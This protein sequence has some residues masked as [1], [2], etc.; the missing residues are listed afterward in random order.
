MYGILKLVILTLY[1]RGWSRAL[2]W[3]LV[4]LCQVEGQ[5]EAPPWLVLKG[6][7]FKIVDNNL[8]L[9]FF[10]SIGGNIKKSEYYDI[11]YYIF[12]FYL[13]HKCVL[14]QWQFFYFQVKGYFFFF[15]LSCISAPKLDVPK[16]GILTLNQL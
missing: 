5:P 10:L 8:I 1:Y 12:L 2:I 7:V 14:I 15:Y 11:E 3:V 9:L 13:V 16:I 4:Q 6:K